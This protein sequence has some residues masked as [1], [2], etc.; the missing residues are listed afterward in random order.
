MSS[1][2]IGGVAKEIAHT[3]EKSSPLFTSVT[4]Y[5]N[6][7]KNFFT[8]FPRVTH[9]L[10]LFSSKKVEDVLVADLY[11]KKK[12]E[13]LSHDDLSI[14]WEGDRNSI[15]EKLGMEYVIT[16]LTLLLLSS[17]VAEQSGRFI[18]MDNSTSNAK[19]YLERL[20]LEF[21]K[22]RQAAITREVTESSA[23]GCI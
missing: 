21:N 2:T 8:Y 14:I 6:V 1:A 16:Q 4:C 3:I 9:L 11:E 12:I 10:P 7:F 19:R 15:L 23:S 17:V 20:Q 5:S 18:A 13:S 22:T